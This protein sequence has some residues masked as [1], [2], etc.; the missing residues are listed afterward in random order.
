MLDFQERM[1]IGKAERMRQV[2]RGNGGWPFPVYAN[3]RQRFA[4]MSEEDWMER[5]RDEA[6]WA[7]ECSDWW[8]AED[9]AGEVDAPPAGELQDQTEE[10]K[11][12]PPA[13][14][15]VHPA[16]SGVQHMNAK[17]YKQACRKL[18]IS[19]YASAKVLGISLS[20]AQ[21]YAGGQWPVPETVAK[22]LR[23]L[24]KLGLTEI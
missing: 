24:V 1:A 20:S 8:K 14:P 21:R 22:L 2:N 9:V 23:A 5:E 7:A 16:R 10:R 19:I 17:E 13:K 6:A 18:G 11:V 3:E 12:P 15:I 4:S